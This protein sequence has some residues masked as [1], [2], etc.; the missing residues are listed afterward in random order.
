[1]KRIL[2]PT[3]FSP[4]AE[5]AFR[6]ALELAAQREGKVYLFHVYT[7]VE[8]PFIETVEVRREYNLEREQALMHDLHR[9]RDQLQPQYPQVS[10]TVVLARSPLVQSTLRFCHENNIDLLV[11]GTQGASGL[12]K[13]LLGTIAARLLEKTEVPLLLVPEE[14]AWKKPRELV[15]ATTTPQVD[16]TALSTASQLADCF[17]AR[18]TA[19]HLVA[20]EVEELEKVQEEFSRHTQ[21]LSL[22][23]EVPSL[24][25]KVL[26]NW[27]ISE[28]LET[29][30]EEVPYDL[31]VMV[32]R[33]KT[34]LQYFYQESL[35]QH[36]AYLT[37]LP[38]LVIPPTPLSN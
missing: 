6:Y 7:P 17:D 38:L 36:M 1:M 31:L 12:K 37:R 23:L 22:E 16:L 15:I 21:Q 3:D 24:S 25:G 32:K 26:R 2:V 5:K 19:V 13:V 33:K 35:T 8:S 27:S 29:L 9:L 10:V 18:L 30:H 14:F 34:F 28:G 4:T 11:M 20:G